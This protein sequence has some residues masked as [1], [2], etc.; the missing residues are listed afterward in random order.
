AF[1]AKSIKNNIKEKKYMYQQL[2]KIGVPYIKTE[3]N[4][5][6]IMFKRPAR[7]IAAALLKKG[8]IVRPMDSFGMSNAI[9]VTIGRPADNQ[10]F[11]Q[12]LKNIL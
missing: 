7:D 9:R 4:F 6:A 1:V 8:I 3:A 2:D 10:R 12:A 5:I 11:I